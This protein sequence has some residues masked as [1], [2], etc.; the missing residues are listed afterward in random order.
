MS[1]SLLAF[2]AKKNR[3]LTS[4][5]DVRS[6]VACWSQPTITGSVQ[7]NSMEISSSRAAYEHDRACVPAPS[8]A[9]TGL[10]RTDD[11]I[12]VPLHVHVDHDLHFLLLIVLFITHDHYLLL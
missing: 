12:K 10:K 6:K 8:S 9:A 11:A 5:F 1:R 7:T 4:Q 3:V 2:F